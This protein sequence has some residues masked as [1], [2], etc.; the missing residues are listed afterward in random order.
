MIE[1]FNVNNEIMSSTIQYLTEKRVTVLMLDSTC[2]SLLKSGN[3]FSL[4]TKARKIL[5]NALYS[6]LHSRMYIFSQ[7]REYIHE[8]ALKDI[9]TGKQR[10]N[11]RF[12]FD[13]CVGLNSGQKCF[14]LPSKHV[15]LLHHPEQEKPKQALEDE[16]EKPIVTSL[17]PLSYPLL[18][19][20]QIFFF[21]SKHNME[22]FTKDPSSYLHSTPASKPVIPK[23]YIIGDKDEL[24]YII[25]YV[26]QKFNMVHINQ[27]SLSE[28]LNRNEGTNIGKQLLSNPSDPNILAVVRIHF[29]KIILCLTL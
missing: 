4:T 23:I 21:N 18:F 1:E 24:Q 13:D 2:C 17:P 11:D 28:T 14:L 19:N 5:Q 6:C 26:A 12:Y 3:E 8:E 29:L 10:L 16:E 25:T 27:Q 15:C 20:G 22:R 7:T 9:S